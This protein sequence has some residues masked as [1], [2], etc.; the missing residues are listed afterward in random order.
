MRVAARIVL[1]ILQW[2]LG[3]V[4]VAT[5]GEAADH[6]FGYSSGVGQV[7]LFGSLSLASR[8]IGAGDFRSSEKRLLANSLQRRPLLLASSPARESFSASDA[9]WVATFQRSESCAMASEETN[10]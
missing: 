4:L 9:Q 10:V 7:I 3:A 5:I 2:V 6:Y 1:I 8:C